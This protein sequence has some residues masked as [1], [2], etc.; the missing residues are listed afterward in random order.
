MS[1]Q[2]PEKNSKRVASGEHDIKY[3]I[4]LT[5]GLI[6]F[7]MLPFSLQNPRKPVR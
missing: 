6:L 2:V 3:H 5:R 4:V 7:E 1:V